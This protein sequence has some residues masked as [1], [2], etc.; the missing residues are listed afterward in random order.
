MYLIYVVVVKLKIVEKQVSLLFL[1][2][3]PLFV[4]SP[5][6]KNGRGFSLLSGLFNFSH[7]LL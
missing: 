6:G 3:V 5:P 2:A 7:S 4:A 1:T